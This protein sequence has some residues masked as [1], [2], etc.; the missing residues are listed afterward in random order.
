MNS[1]VT[2]P[3]TGPAAH[4]S[5]RNRRTS[6]VQVLAR[7]A[8]PAAPRLAL[9]VAAGVAAAGAGVGLMATSAWLI[10]RAATHPP[11]LHLM[12]A[13]VAVRA[14]GLSRGFFR[15]AE[16]LVGHDA[17][18]RVLAGL[19]VRYYARLAR[20]APAGLRGYR[21]G[22]LVE[23]LVRDVDAVLDVLVRVVLPYAVALGVA[24]GSVA[25]V[26]ALLPPAGVA[27]AVALAAATV[28]VP[29]VQS[30]VTCRADARLAPLRGELASHT[31]DLLH[32]LADLTA[33]GAV[34]DR[35]RQV[36]QVDDRLRAATASASGTTGVGTAVT[37]ALAG[38][39]AVV[40]LAT[41]TVAV[42]AGTLP[43]ELLAVVVLTPL[44]V[45]EA[46]AGLPVAAAR[47]GTA[48]AAL[49][50]VAAVLAAADPTPEP[51]APVRMPGG[52]HTVALRGVSAE[53]APGRPALHSVDLELRPG[54]RV[55]LVGASGSGK[56][57][58]AALL[59]RFLDPTAGAVTIDGVDLREL[60]SDEVRRIIGLCDD[61]AYLF[62]STIEANLRIGRPDATVEQLR[63]ALAE[64]RLLEWVQTLPDGLATAV[65]EH[66]V[67]LSGGQ[68]RRLALARVL[69]AD[70]EVL[71][72]DEP[73]EHLDE[74]TA[75]AVMRDLLAATTG[76][77]TLLITHRTVELAELSDLDEIVVLDR[78]R[79]A[80][81]SQPT[82]PR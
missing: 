66:G 65:G 19:R 77:T 9:A 43:G 76:R 40:A 32:G 72:L 79:I 28:A 15:Y 33:Y 7:A 18:L 11:V 29:M 57:T 35:L 6:W 34:D 36:S 38:G 61:E 75:T 56:S 45:F 41:G 22:D 12:V 63:S 82:T 20:L 70:P 2:G 62:D 27:L 17:A 71:V 24:V 13:I 52:P 50:R 46:I 81:R 49:A 1:D 80:R 55:A 73:T 25:L 4:P 21:R 37:T 78:G 44:A 10:S 48:R 60:P 8:R 68:R 42:D 39:C 64:A 47:L 5:G 31:V 14:F 16:R 67:R 54:R 69:L 59:V 58:V 3:A 26:G 53:W 30:A 51:V 23:R 74:V